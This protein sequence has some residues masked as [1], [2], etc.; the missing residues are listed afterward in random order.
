MGLGPPPPLF[1]MSFQLKSSFLKRS[2]HMLQNNRFSYRVRY[3]WGRVSNFDQSEARKQC[4]LAS[5]WLKFE[6]LPRK[7]RTLYFPM[8]YITPSRLR[9]NFITILEKKVWSFYLQLFESI[10]RRLSTVF[11]QEIRIFGY[12]RKCKYLNQNLIRHSHHIIKK[13]LS[14]QLCYVT[15]FVMFRNTKGRPI[16]A[17]LK[18]Q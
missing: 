3:F 5:D 8:I 16:T 11:S 12:Y 13:L 18:I 14:Y 6:A 7:Y 15:S 4:F 1:T 2:C 17:A 10:V 9:F